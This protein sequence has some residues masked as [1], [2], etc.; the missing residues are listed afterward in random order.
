MKKNPVLEKKYQEGL[1]RGIEI[2]K[3]LAREEGRLE[4]RDITTDWIKERFD[5]LDK[6]PGI[7]P[8]IFE[9]LVNH[10]GPQ[11]FKKVEK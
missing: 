10:F 9:K 1:L 4:G 11:Y 6:V 7:G 8:K 3:A 5:G 2:G